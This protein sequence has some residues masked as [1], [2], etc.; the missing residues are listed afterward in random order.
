MTVSFFEVNNILYRRPYEP[1]IGICLDGTSPEY[2]DRAI[3]SGYTPVLRGLSEKGWLGRARSIMP[4]YTN[5]NNIAI[6]TGTTSDKNGI[7]GNYFYDSD[8]DREVMMNAPEFL[9]VPSIFEIAFKNRCRI[10]VV[11]A[12]DKLLKLLSKGWE[13]PAFS[14]ERADRAFIEGIGNV[15]EKLGKPPPHY[16]EA[17]INPY[18][19]KAAYLVFHKFR[20]DIMYISLTDCVQHRAAP[21]E[22][23][24]ND[25]LS[26]IDEIIGRFIQKGARIGLTADHGMNDKVNADG[27]PNIVYLSD[28]ISELGVD[29]YRVILPITDPYVSHHSALGSFATIY[30]SDSHLVPIKTAVKSKPGISEVLERKDA[31][32]KYALPFDRIGD[33]VIIADKHTVLGKTPPSHDLSLLKGPLRSHGGLTETTVPFGFSGPVNGPETG[34]TPRNYE[35]FDYLMNRFCNF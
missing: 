18:T 6:V 27:T 2:L 21:G 10:A 15:A 13:G 26:Q 25:M 9:W 28:V 34:E 12:K 24:A 7:C 30:C 11:T 22:D 19:M 35:L 3:D 32:A 4:S 16:S 33:L 20:P 1:I 29:N 23:E 17:R 5:P 14:G 8:H 31:C